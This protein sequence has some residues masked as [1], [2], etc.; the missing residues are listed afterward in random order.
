MG[1]WRAHG[2]RRQR[3]GG[4]EAG[5]GGAAV[6]RRCDA[7][8]DRAGG[9][10]RREEC[11]EGGLAALLDDL[12]PTGRGGRA[13]GSPL[14]AADLVVERGC[15]ALGVIEEAW[16]GG[17]LDQFGGGCRQLSGLGPGLTPSGDDL[18]AG[19]A[20]G[21]RAAQGSL[22]EEVG[23]AISGATEGRTTDLARARVHHAV[24]GHADEYTDAVLRA[25]V[26]DTDP[27]LDGAVTRMLGYGHTSGVD[28]L[29][30]LVAGLRLGLDA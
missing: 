10:C 28:T 17:G 6:G 19:L 22:Q 24:D 27:G 8:P 4:V 18:L 2:D 1:H 23:R 29:V 16:R 7:G 15:E 30:G 13:S 5:A 21:L 12:A 11:A 9:G 25:L 14:R 26:M 20:L 3:G